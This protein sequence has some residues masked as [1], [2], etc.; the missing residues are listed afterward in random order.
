MSRNKQDRRPSIYRGD[1]QPGRR[2]P[3]DGVVLKNVAVRLNIT[4]SY[5]SQIITG[6][7]VPSM[8]LA[9]EI[10]GLLGWTL[11]DVAALK[12]GKVPQVTADRR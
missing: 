10:A 5:L 9:G 12:S 2:G 8:R 7:R 4:P 6:K 1:G 3:I 11:D